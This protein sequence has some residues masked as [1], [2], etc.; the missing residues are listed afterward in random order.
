MY[1]SKIDD[2][3]D[4]VIDDFYLN[5][6]S[7]KT[8][9]KIFKEVNFVKFQKEINIL[10]S[11]FIKTINLTEIREL[12]KSND[13]VHAISEAL[14]RYVAFYFFLTVGF[15]Y[16][17]KDDTFINNIVEFTKNQPEFGFKID[18]F[19]NSESNSLLI[20]YNTMVKNIL[21]LL[22]ADQAKI[23]ILKVKP[24]YQDTIMFLNQH[25]GGEYINKNFVMNGS[26]E[27]HEQGH[28]IIKTIIVLL[29]YKATEKKEFFRLIEMTENLDGEYMFI[30]VVIPKQKYIDYNSV[31]KLIGSSPTVKNLSYYLWD[32]ITEYEESLQKPPISIDEK[33][34]LLIESGILY[35]ISDDFLLYHKDSERYDKAIDP[36]KIK[37][38]EKG[39]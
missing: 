1:I 17:S 3:I 5:I 34:L 10:I 29:L 16:K 22:D 8:L 28:N 27:K 35:P 25:V 36:N 39:N 21:T 14:K 38:K 6:L 31:E 13:T 37:K 30:D 19:F 2:L 18:N 4:K 24:D 7:D 9:P 11:D 15:N 32:F 26:M 20:K 33:L 23:D 12:V